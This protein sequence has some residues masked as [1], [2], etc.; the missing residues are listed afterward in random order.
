M[1][2]P[3]SLCH[4]DGRCPELGALCPHPQ[5]HPWLWP[6][7]GG[8]H[9]EGRGTCWPQLRAEPS[10]PEEPACGQPAPEGSLTG[11]WGR[12]CW[13]TAPRAGHGA[14][15]PLARSKSS[16]SPVMLRRGARRALADAA[17]DEAVPRP[18]QQTRCCHSAGPRRSTLGLPNRREIRDEP[19]GQRE[20]YKLYMEQLRLGTALRMSNTHARTLPRIPAF[21]LCCGWV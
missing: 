2:S 7:Q 9:A 14:G 18:A 11:A 12:R 5:Q 4:S 17:R 16:T 15:A 19:Q 20:A 3:L 13:E 10:P 1:G 21:A 6:C 8:Q